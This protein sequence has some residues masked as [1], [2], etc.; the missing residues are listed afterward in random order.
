MELSPEQKEQLEK[1]K[2]QC[3]FCKIVKGEIPSKKVYE[4]DK[5]MA[6]LDINPAAKG[7]LLVMPKEHYPIMPLIPE[8][9]FKHLFSKVKELD[10]AVK[11]AFLCK[12]CT[13]FVANGGA[14]GQQSMH[15]ML[16]I[17]PRDGGD[18]L[19]ML[20]ISGKE[21]PEK[22]VAEVVEKCAVLNPMLLKNL[23][24]LGYTK[25]QGDSGGG[26]GGM[27]MPQKVTKEQLMQIIEKNPQ[28][29][30]AILQSPGQ[31]KQIVPNHPQLK[32]LFK[33][34]DLDQIIE[35]VRSKSKKK[36]KIDLDGIG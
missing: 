31:F 13:I 9:T 36:G 24:A 4:D 34:F 2:E 7:H 25:P 8:E 30:Q 10:G 27:M 32:E 11:D 15:F 17:I 16:H 28:I 33:D 20:D 22:E 6:I 5:I 26:A 35:E 12:E 1:Q 21:A 3:I 23:A 29:K 19:E 18:G 14:A